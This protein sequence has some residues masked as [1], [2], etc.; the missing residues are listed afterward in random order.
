VGADR[1]QYGCPDA[2]SSLTAAHRRFTHEC[3]AYSG[4]VSLTKN[5]VKAGEKIDIHVRLKNSSRQDLNFSYPEGDPLTCG[6]AVYDDNRN[7]VA[8][9][10]LG[11]RLKEQ[12]AGL[13]RPPVSY[14][15]HPG[16][17]QTRDCNVNELYQMSAPGKYS[18]EVQQ[19]DGR[20]VHSNVVAVS[21]VP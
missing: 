17:A 4:T 13:E 19:L 20:P 15:I 3:R 5:V 9:T 8:D 6:V 12:H 1:H 11:L 21:V 16:E 2:P 18:I 14:S 7:A 10:R